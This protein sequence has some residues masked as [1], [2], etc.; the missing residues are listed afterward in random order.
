MGGRAE[1]SA[2]R[3]KKF[4]RPGGERSTRKK[5]FKTFSGRLKHQGKEKSFAKP[6]ETSF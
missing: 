2:V 1:P 3:R 5:H 6:I 4:E